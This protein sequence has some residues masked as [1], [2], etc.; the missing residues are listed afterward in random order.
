MFKPQVKSGPA[1]AE[2]NYPTEQNT[3]LKTDTSPWSPS[4]RNMHMTK[5]LMRA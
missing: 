4:S 3:W 2:I 1:F 5:L